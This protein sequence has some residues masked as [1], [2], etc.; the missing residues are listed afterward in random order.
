MKYKRRGRKTINH[1]IAK[2]KRESHPRVNDLLHPRWIANHGHSDGIPL[3][4]LQRGDRFY[5][6]RN[7]ATMFVV[8]K[9]KS[10]DNHSCEYLK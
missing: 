10:R 5:Y 9:Y 6:S 4:L 8:I 2:G 7:A 1:H 3:S